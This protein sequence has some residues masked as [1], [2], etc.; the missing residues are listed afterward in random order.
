MNLYEKLET[1]GAGSF[2]R[3]NKIRRKSDQKVLVWKEL[4]YG[5]MSEKEKQL[6]VSEVNI[7]R[8]LRNPFIVRY[9]DRIVD[10]ASTRLYIVME[11]CSGGDLG[12][13]IKHQKREGKYVD[14]RLIW[15]VLAQ[16]IL[17]LKDCHRHEENGKGK[18][19]LH[20]DIKPANILLDSNHNV[21]IGDFGLAKE[22]SSES[23]LAQTNVGTPYYM[24]PEIINEKS[25]D[26]RS[27]IWSLGCLIYELAALRP[28]FDAKNQISL[29]V[30]INAGRFL[31]VPKCY[32]DDLQNAIRSMLQVDRRRRPKVEDLERVAAL[33]PAL[34]D[35]NRLMRELR[36]EVTGA[37]KQRDVAA[38]KDKKE[39]EKEE[40]GA[41]RAQL[42]KE[43]RELDARKR[44][45][46]A[47]ERALE[48]RKKELDRREKDLNVREASLK[49]RS[50][51]HPEGDVGR[52]HPQ[53]RSARL[54]VDAACAANMPPPPPPTSV[55]TSAPTS[56]GFTIHMDKENAAPTH[57]NV[58]VNAD[59][60]PTTVG[61][62]ST[63]WQPGL[64]ESERCTNTTKTTAAG[65]TLAGQKRESGSA[66]LAG[67]VK[68]MGNT[69]LRPSSA[70]VDS[71]KRQ[72]VRREP[73]SDHT[74]TNA[75]ATT[76]TSTSHSHAVPA[77]K[78]ELRH[79]LARAQRP[80]AR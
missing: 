49:K 51:E 15:K 58:K 66:V 47:R 35:A 48:V 12:K 78:V 71:N 41:A 45:L 13:V 72:C 6:V 59:A 2:G 79:L 17:A 74:N 1:V 34:S 62:G 46:E 7:L 64:K 21:K 43:Q 75:N 36:G 26:E 68:R 32:S 39:K 25:Y 40:E 31:R 57:V 33:Q 23:K 24:S 18:P 80:V 14:E 54:S 3:V 53:R 56:A 10:K 9:Y 4:N 61:N 5:K 42:D 77:V 50:I 20:R 30:K 16:C 73:L 8:E 29:A 76:G 69:G 27:D 38:T 28:P 55:A 63:K 22:L 19:I 60:K 65:T 52:A 70:W 44:D 37:Q 67:C 11:Y